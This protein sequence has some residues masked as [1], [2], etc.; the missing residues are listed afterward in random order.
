MVLSSY[1]LV[2][3]VGR[4]ASCTHCNARRTQCI[5]ITKESSSTHE[6]L[7]G[8]L[9]ILSVLILC[10]AFPFAIW[11]PHDIL[12]RSNILLDLPHSEHAIQ[13][14]LMIAGL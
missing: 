7:E 5:Q 9:R 12:K 3:S 4:Q 13:H 2:L 6:S 11:C 1:S 8:R 14:L 10:R